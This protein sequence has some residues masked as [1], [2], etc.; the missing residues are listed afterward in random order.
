MKLRIL[1]LAIFLLCGVASAQQPATTQQ[2]TAKSADV[3]SDP[4][5]EFKAA[6]KRLGD[7]Q[8]ALL[9]YQQEFESALA[10]RNAVIW[11]MMAEA[12]IKP[13]ECL[14]DKN[15]FA[16]LKADQT[17]GLITFEKIPVTAKTDVNK[18]KTAN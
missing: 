18:P 9:P 17:T 3:K 8:T 15:P 4:Q 13:S 7:A 5:A 1:I 10:S 16:C 14:V 12:G 6:Q 11:K 2:Q